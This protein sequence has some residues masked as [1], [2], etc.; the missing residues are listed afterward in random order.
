MDSFPRFLNSE[1][2]Q[3]YKGKN[4]F[5]SIPNLVEASKREK[6]KANE[7]LTYLIVRAK[8]SG[9]GITLQSRQVGNKTYPECFVGSF[10][11]HNSTH[12]R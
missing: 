3:K 6:D 12:G 9:R 10:I 4:P 5:R 1:I 7:D 11:V 8:D 2:Y